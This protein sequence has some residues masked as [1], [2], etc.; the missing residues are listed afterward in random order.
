MVA[1]KLVVLAS[2]CVLMGM[3]TLAQDPPQQ[4]S[5]EVPY[6]GLSYAMLSKQGVTVMVAQLHRTILEYSTVQVWISNG[7]KFPVRVSPMYF[8]V[9]ME[10]G[11]PMQATS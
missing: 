6:R 3:P 11:P 8:D 7:S 9:R 1:R 2:L 10:G 5:V 4:P